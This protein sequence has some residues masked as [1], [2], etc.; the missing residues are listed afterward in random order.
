MVMPMELFCDIRPIRRGQSLFCSRLGNRIIP[1]PCSAYFG[2]TGGREQPDALKYDKALDMRRILTDA[3]FAFEYP[4]FDAALPAILSK[5]YGIKRQGQD[6]V[7][8][9]DPLMSLDADYAT[10]RNERLGRLFDVDVSGVA[11]EMFPP[12][13]RELKNVDKALT[14]LLEECISQPFGAFASLLDKIPV[15]ELKEEK[16]IPLRIRRKG[17]LIQTCMWLQT[18]NIVL[19]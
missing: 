19:V 2:D 17:M 5:I 12:S 18:Y 13:T 14:P 10:E 7:C 6:S 16:N 1:T 15:Q 4:Q 11:T 9:C 8:F 3:L